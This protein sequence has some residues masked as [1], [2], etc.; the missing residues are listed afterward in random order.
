M[1]NLVVANAPAWMDGVS[2]DG[3]HMRRQV[4]GGLF[5]GAQIVE[6]LAV[7]ALPTPSMKVRVPAGLAMVDDGTGGFYPLDNAAQVDLD[8]AASSGAQGR[9]DSVIAE[10]LDTGSSGTALYRFRVITGTPSGSPVVPTLPAAD[11]PTAKTLR[12]AN[13]FV[14]PN[15]ETNGMVRAQ[16]VTVVAAPAVAAVIAPVKTDMVSAPGFGSVNAWVDFTSGQWPTASIKV[17]PSG[18]LKVTVSGGNMANSNSTTATTRVAFRISGASTV[19]ADPLDSKCVLAS[20]EGGRSASRTFY[21]T[22]LTVGGTVTITPQWRI[23]S[24]SSSTCTLSAGQLL[25]EPA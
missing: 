25:A 20:G 2:V 17:P 4:Y 9:Y 19:S 23:S 21:A 3:A 1:A 16:D 12:I 8:I 18:N 7:S 5:P 6:G 14:Q 10:I 24:G 15:A 11:Q 13:V 22:G